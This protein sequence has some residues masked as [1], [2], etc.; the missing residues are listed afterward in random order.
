MLHGLNH[1][2]LLVGLEIPDLRIPDYY[3]PA[4]DMYTFQF[5]E[6]NNKPETQVWY[7]TCTN[8]WP[9]VQTAI[10]KV[11]DLR[12]EITQ[13]YEE[14]FPAIIPN[15]KVGP[16][17]EPQQQNKSPLA[18]RK[19][20]FIADIIGLGI[21]AFSAISQHRKQ[22]KLEKGMKQLKHRQNVLDHKIEALEDGMISITK[23]TFDELDY[24]KKELELTGYNI[25]VLTTEI[26]N[27]QYQLSRH[28]GRISIL[29]HSLMVLFL[30]YY[31][32]WKDIWH[33]MKE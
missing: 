19:K 24:L 29:F 7:K 20:R 5:C 9:A 6:E 28:M 11:H 8:V 23:E 12:Y 25:K 1:Y 2:N 22:S 3:T 18:S 33:Y 31:L 32:K 10:T 21:Q 13:I 30:C 15:Y 4:Q 26:K 17:Q 27:V 14:E 16:I